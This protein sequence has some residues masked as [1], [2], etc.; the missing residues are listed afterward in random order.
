MRRYNFKEFELL[1][2]QAACTFNKQ[3]IIVVDTNIVIIIAVVFGVNG[4]SLSVNN[5]VL[6]ETEQFL[7]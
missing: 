3:N 5:N 1:K 7:Y 6:S 4:P 2:K